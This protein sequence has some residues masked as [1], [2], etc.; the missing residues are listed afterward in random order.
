MSIYFYAKYGC[1]CITSAVTEVNISKKMK[2]LQQLD[3]IKQSALMKSISKKGYI[4]P[5]KATKTTRA[6]TKT[7]P[8]TRSKR[9]PASTKKP[10]SQVAR[11]KS[12]KK[13]PFIVTAFVFGIIGAYFLVSS[14]ADNSIGIHISP[15]AINLVTTANGPKTVT[16]STASKRNV[17]SVYVASNG[18]TAN[19]V[20]VTQALKKGTYEVCTL[21]RPMTSGSAGKLRVSDKPYGTES[22]LTSE[23]AFKAT[24]S[25]DYIKLACPTI[26]LSND[27]TVYI[28][29][30][31]TKGSYNF[32]IDAI[33]PK[34]TPTTPTGA[35]PCELK[36]AAEA[37]WAANT[38]P[39]N[40]NGGR[41]SAAQI[42]GGQSNLRKVT[43]Q[44]TAPAG[45]TYSGGNLTVNTAGAV[46]DRIWLD[47]CI[48]INAKNVTIKNSLIRSSSGCLGGNGSGG[49]NAISSGES[50]TTTGLVI[51]DT[52]VDGLN[53]NYDYTVVGTRDF[54]CVRCNV[55]GGVKN[56][57]A[58]SNVTIKESYI[59]HPST[60][61][62]TIHGEAIM[63]DSG[64]NVT[65]DHS[66]VSA[67]GAPTMT[68][69][70]Q[71]LA[72]WGPG[73]GLTINNSYLEGGVGADLA[74]DSRATNIRITNNA[75]SN[76]NGY[77]GT[78]FVY[79]FNPN[80]SGNVWTGNYVPQTGKNLNS[81]GQQY[82]L[83]NP[84]NIR[85]Q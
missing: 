59:H 60:R 79:G 33:T 53:A 52:E 37:C 5:K 58:G 6:S 15:R 77:G 3:T 26:T 39:T 76:V 11:L 81:S 23:A 71:F 27:T 64:S 32:S 57:W 43:S 34:A 28:S 51:Q 7:K 61:G 84:S 1:L 44:A 56:V 2:F 10:K 16:D 41:Y 68:G 63:A 54:T 82:L 62:G 38:G 13:M 55:H 65:I 70:V 49:S 75:F 35:V 78:N 8:S 9:A 67:T 40:P 69:A 72:S 66:W 17:K 29:H 83:D 20:S 31:V 25:A 46:I 74:T 22:A 30:V 48:A 19:Q 14:Y 24:T 80:G 4:M 85:T 12:S 47:G 42:V 50:G 18:T 73:N 36:P 45:T 21:G